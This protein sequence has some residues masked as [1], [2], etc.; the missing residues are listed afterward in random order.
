LTINLPSEKKSPAKAE[1]NEKK[2][3]VAN[4]LRKNFRH[5]LGEISFLNCGTE[6]AISNDTTNEILS[7][8][9]LELSFHSRVRSD[10][11]Q[12]SEKCKNNRLPS[13]LFHTVLDGLPRMYSSRAPTANSVAE[14]VGQ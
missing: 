1:K 3:P 5:E 11:K 2:R 6:R 10:Q 9:N 7:K 8:P 4:V 13:F 12:E 14:F